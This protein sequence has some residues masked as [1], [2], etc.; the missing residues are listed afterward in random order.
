MHHIH[1][2]NQ[3]PTYARIGMLSKQAMVNR[4]ENGGV[5]SFAP[6]GYRNLPYTGGQVTLHPTESP[7]MHT[8]F[9]QAG[10]LQP[11]RVICRFLFDHGMQSRTGKPIGPSALRY[12]LTNPF[13]IGLVKVDGRYVKG[14]HEPLV[15][16]E[17]FKRVCQR[18]NVKFDSHMEAILDKK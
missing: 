3:D 14:T 11:L 2:I 7:L 18:F 17:L 6:N 10:D 8:A 16:V 13:Y 12:M 9:Q 15:S 4:V 1:K 5:A